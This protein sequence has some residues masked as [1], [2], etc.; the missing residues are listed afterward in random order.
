[1]NRSTETTTR[2]ETSAAR[3]PQETAEAEIRGLIADWSRALEAK[4]VT[5]MMANY[6]PDVVLFDAIPPYKT[7]G[8]ENVRKAWEG[9]FPYFPEKFRSEHRDLTIHVDGDLA[10]VHGLHHFAP[11]PADHPCGATW[12]RI[13]VV[14]RRIEGQWKVVHEHVSIPFNPITQQAFYIPNPDVIEVPSYENA[15]GPSKETNE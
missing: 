5:Q 8:V 6:S 11:T 12:S 7:I 13:T 15:G 14:Y 10:V 3:P 9:C 1:M 4:D 2:R